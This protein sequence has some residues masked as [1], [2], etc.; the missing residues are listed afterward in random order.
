MDNNYQVLF[1]QLQCAHIIC[2]V[3]VTKTTKTIGWAGGSLPFHSD[4]Q[5]PGGYVWVRTLW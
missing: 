4:N 3:Q 1:L 2:T 5:T